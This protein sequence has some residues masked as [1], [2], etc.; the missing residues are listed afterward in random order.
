[1]FLFICISLVSVKIKNELNHDFSYFVAFGLMPRFKPV[2]KHLIN[3]FSQVPKHETLKYCLLSQQSQR[4]SLLHKCKPV[5]LTSGFN[6]SNPNTL[7]NS[8]MCICFGV[9]GYGR[10]LWLWFQQSL[11]NPEE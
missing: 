10:F 4:F 3:G 11:N 9:S 8:V 6:N 7:I 2:F 1:M 5:T